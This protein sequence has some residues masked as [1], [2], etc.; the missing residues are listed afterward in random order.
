[1]SRAE[2]PLVELDK[3]VRSEMCM[4]SVEGP[5]PTSGICDGDSNKLCCLSGSHSPQGCVF[6]EE[7]GITVHI[8]AYCN[9]INTLQ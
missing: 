1:M 6:L 7:C 4:S 9:F 3:S 8:T 2:G 5:P